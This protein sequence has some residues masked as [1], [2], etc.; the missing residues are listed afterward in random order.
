MLRW[1]GQR[2]SWSSFSGCCR[3]AE[4]GAYVIR[5]QA[6]TI[7]W[8]CIECSIALFSASRARS[9]A[10]LAFGFDS[11]VELLSAVVVV[12]QFRQAFRISSQ[13]AARWA[14]ILLIVLGAVVAAESIAAAI[15]LD[16]RPKTT[17][18]GLGITITALVVM[19]GLAWAKRKGARRIG[20]RAL[21]ADA[22]QSATCAYLAAI[23]LCGFVS[24]AMFHVAWLDP[25]AALAAVPILGLEGKRALSGNR[26]C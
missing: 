5:L 8:M 17:G 4:N 15:A 18:L 24:N 26:Y 12:L 16:L 10:L 25:V 14:G 3:G 2:L 13:Q 23:A 21:A 9:P 22:V 7:V 1:L 6:I 20:N 19:P 11:L